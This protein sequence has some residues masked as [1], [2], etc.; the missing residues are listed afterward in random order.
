MRTRQRCLPAHLPSHSC[1]RYSWRCTRPLRARLTRPRCIFHRAPRSRT[2]TS[3]RG[4]QHHH[5]RHAHACH[6]R[7]GAIFCACACSR[8]CSRTH[9]LVSPYGTARSSAPPRLPGAHCCRNTGLGTHASR[10]RRCQSPPNRP[11]SRP[12]APSIS[13]VDTSQAGGR[14]MPVL[15]WRS[16]CKSI[17]TTDRR[18][19]REARNR[20][21]RRGTRERPASACEPPCL[22]ASY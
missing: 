1:V 14:V 22:C 16:P 8:Y 18:G 17:E 4:V 12:P 19:E 9:E 20:T 11:S 15:C 7:G 2:R 6:K 3:S 5:R 10:C 21:A 13:Y